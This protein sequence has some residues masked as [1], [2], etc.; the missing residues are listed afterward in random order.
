MEFLAT[1]SGWQF[2]RQFESN[3]HRM[4]LATLAFGIIFAFL[5]L[6]FLGLTAFSDEDFLIPGVIFLVFGLGF[7]ASAAVARWLS[8]QWEKESR[9]GN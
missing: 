5:G 1:E 4:I 7:A 3:P 8:M 6:G 2:M 9:N